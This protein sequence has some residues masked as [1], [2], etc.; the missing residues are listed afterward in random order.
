MP[1]IAILLYNGMHSA[2][3]DWFQCNNTNEYFSYLNQEKICSKY[4]K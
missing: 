1:G 3:I 2:G 4:C